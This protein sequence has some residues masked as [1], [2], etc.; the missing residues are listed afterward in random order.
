MFRSINLFLILFL[1][2]LLLSC[3]RP[4]GKNS[5]S[6]TKEG[7]WYSLIAYSQDNDS[8]T[9]AF[10][11][12]INAEFKTQNDSVFFDTKNDLRDRFFI[13]SSPASQPNFLKKAISYCAEGDSMCVLIN[14][15]HFF[16]QQF[17]SSV[18]FF[19]IK[20]SIVKVNF[21]VKK[22]LT[23][24]E[25]AT[26]TQNIAN[27]EQLEIDKYFGSER[28]AELSKDPLGFYWVQKPESSD[29]S[30]VYLGQLVT[31]Q[32]SGGFLNGRIID[33]SP[34]EFKLIYG[35]PDQLI[36]GLNI[37]ISRL[38]KGQTSKIVLPSHLAF[39][40]NGSS[41]GSVPPFTPMLYNI[42]I[43]DIKTNPEADQN[44]VRKKTKS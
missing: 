25:L 38:K 27:E 8:V 2:F 18:P 28:K 29:T 35:T 16:S 32:Y 33:N 13:K 21:K 11:R 15:T 4:S 5:Y 7:Y 1:S 10:S 37:V 20:D 42:K 44:P 24:Q 34:Q 6:K 12:W 43:I 17:K 26:L 22:L 31:L 19:C 14:P 39:G 9:P 3:K 36:K 41:N 23:Q 30:R 40:E